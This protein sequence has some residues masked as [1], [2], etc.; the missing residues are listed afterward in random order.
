MATRTEPSPFTKF[1]ILIILACFSIALLA[2]AWLPSNWIT[3][4]PYDSRRVLESILLV[5]FPF[6]AL[7][8]KGYRDIYQHG[9]RL[10]PQY[11]YILIGLFFIF[12]ILSA[13]QSFYPLQGLL[14]ISQYW[15]LMFFSLFIA[16]LTQ[17][18]PQA[19]RWLFAILFF[20][21]LIYVGVTLYNYINILS[22]L[23]KLK[24]HPHINAILQQLQIMIIY[25]GFTNPRFFNQVITW[26]LPLLVLPLL[27]KKIPLTI[28]IICLFLC[29]YWWFL[30]IA[31][32]SRSLI[33]EW[34]FILILLPIFFRK[35][36]TAFFFSHMTAL[37]LGVIIYILILMPLNNATIKNHDIFLG[38]E[39]PRV[40]KM[41]ITSTEDREVLW[42]IAHQNIIQHPILGTGPGTYPISA[43]KNGSSFGHPHN[44]ILQ[45][46][47]SWGIPAI[48]VFLLLCLMGLFYWFKQCLSLQKKDLNTPLNIPLLLSASLISGGAHALISGIIVMPLSQ[49]LMVVII[50]LAL[51]TYATGRTKTHSPQK[52]LSHY[53][54][55]PITLI[56]C[57]TISTAAIFSFSWV[58]GQ[59][60][61]QFRQ[62][63]HA[64][65]APAYWMNGELILDQIASR[66]EGYFCPVKKA[67]EK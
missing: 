56:A 41:D 25:P 36:S 51:G 40:L 16:G 52:K 17:V 42:D 63:C 27:S 1:S 55:T 14:I 15:L 2:F 59:Y 65:Y 50:G 67:A 32:G 4:T 48:L 26:V 33:L 46:A 49:L 43:Y 12:G 23:P 13:Q 45:L 6:L 54:L 38:I 64:N 22:M 53:I 20:S 8:F 30:A 37:F 21:C 58:S 62:T 18:Y 10:L 61:L 57:L 3:I 47:S 39:P 24:G 28:K 7:F 66:K 44:A 11:A 31:S 60:M 19:F 35:K 34:I 9:L 5:I 29:G